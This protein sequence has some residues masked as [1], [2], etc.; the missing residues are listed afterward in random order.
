MPVETAQALAELIKRGPGPEVLDVVVEIL[1]FHNR[2]TSVAAFVPLLGP[3]LVARS[4][5]RPDRKFKLQCISAGLTV[6]TILGAVAL[7]R[8]LSAPAVPL[9]ERLQAQIATLGE[10]ARE[11]R[12]KHGAHPDA[13]TWKRTAAQP[14]LR[15]FDPWSRPYRYEPTKDGGVTIGTLGGDG[16]EGGSGENADVSVHFAP[17][18]PVPLTAR[19]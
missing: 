11:F 6:L 17:P 2:M 15:F 16:E 19:P 12:V 1:T 10:I 3:W 18:D 5:T 9:R 8:A 7:A 4:E 13:A 14:D